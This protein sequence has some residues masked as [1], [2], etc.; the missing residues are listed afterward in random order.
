[1]GTF[2]Y[3]LAAYLGNLLSDVIPTE[4]SCSD[5]FTF[6]EELKKA[7]INDKFMISFDV[8]SL[9]TNIPLKETLDLAV[10]AILEKKPQLKI[11]KEELLE[12][13]LFAT[14]KTNFLFNGKVYDQIDGVA[15]GSPLAPI[16]ANLF[17]GHH[18]KEWL[19]NF[20]GVAPSFYRRYVDDIF[21]V[22]DN[23]AQALS[24]FIYLN[25]RHPSIK[26]T[27]DDVIEPGALPFLDVYIKNQG[28]VCTSVY[29][30]ETYTG[31]LTNFRSFVPFVYKRMLVNTL[32]DR[33]FKISNTWIGFDLDIK[34]LTSVL[35]KNMFPIKM[36]ENIIGKYLSKKIS[37]SSKT[38]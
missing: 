19:E 24:F 31:L 16:L 20:S 11:T 23:E 14:S 1:M 30:K 17:M 4:H 12:L 2:N 36:I 28:E 7:N 34:K 21:L 18:E 32:V 13:F 35:C 15:M 38:P 33:I 25:E 27:K 3:N 6:V 22:F 9:F 26:F 8:V 29:Q 37:V 10:N 5:T